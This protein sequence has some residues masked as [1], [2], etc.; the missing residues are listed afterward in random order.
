MDKNT[1]KKKTDLHV[2]RVGAPGGH[3]AIDKSFEVAKGSVALA[4]WGRLLNNSA[5]L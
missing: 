3:Q 5:P 2:C 1:V 4:S